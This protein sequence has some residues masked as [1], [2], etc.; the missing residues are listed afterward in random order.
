MSLESKKLLLRPDV[1]A[2]SRLPVRTD[3]SLMPGSI[4]SRK[5]G[6]GLSLVKDDGGQKFKSRLR[7][8][9][10]NPSSGSNLSV[11]VVREQGV[12]ITCGKFELKIDAT[13]SAHLNVCSRRLPH[14]AHASPNFLCA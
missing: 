10:R 4:A 7:E 2:I 6:V 9:R 8:A 14:S 1:L 5:R 11:V 3:K 13:R 12:A